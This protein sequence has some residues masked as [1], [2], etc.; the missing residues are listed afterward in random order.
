MQ[1]RTSRIRPSKSH[2]RPGRPSLCDHTGSVTISAFFLEPRL[3]LSKSRIRLSY[4]AAHL[5]GPGIFQVPCSRRMTGFSTDEPSRRM[6]VSQ[7]CLVGGLIRIRL[8]FGLLLGCAVEF[9]SP[10]EP[11]TLNGRGWRLLRW[12]VAGFGLAQTLASLRLCLVRRFSPRQ[13]LGTI[14]SVFVSSRLPA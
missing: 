3:H 10:A 11:V 1:G 4:Y 2:A 12:A 13:R 9:A 7:P 5:S 8:R 14:G 6:R